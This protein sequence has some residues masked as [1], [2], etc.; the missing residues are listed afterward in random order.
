M[1]EIN[2]I[3]MLGV[4]GTGM[5]SLA[6]LLKQAG[7]KVS[8]SDKKLYPPMS[9][10]LAELNIKIYE[11]FSEKNLEDKP[12]LVVIGNVITKDNIEAQQVL[13]RE[14]PYISMPQALSKFFLNSRTPIVVAGTHGKTTTSMLLAWCFFSAGKEPGF[15]IGGVGNNFK[16]TA[17]IGKGSPFII[18]GDEYDTAFFDKGPKFL[19]YSP[20]IVLLTSVEFDHGD[21]YKDLEQIKK[22]FA[23][24]ISIIPS[25]GLLVYNGDDEN[26]REL[27]KASKIRSLSYGMSPVLDYFPSSFSFSGNGTSFHLKGPNLST[28]FNFA[29]F[30]EHNLQNAMGVIAVLKELGMSDEDIEKGLTTFLGVRRRQEIA[31]EIKSITIVDDFAHHPTAVA[32]TIQAIKVKFPERRLWAIFEPRSN[33]SRRN[34]F[35]EEYVAALSKADRVVIG[36]VYCSEKIPSDERLDVRGVAAKIMRKGIDAHYI[37]NTEFIIEFLMRNINKNDVILVMSNGDFNNLIS[38]IKEGLNK[39][40]IV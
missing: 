20:K 36:D 30:G 13:K 28:N 23:K 16:K 10:Q 25:D 19:H 3:H 31:A 11:G 24:L 35:K 7:Y 12:D 15:F 8:G 38:K 18:E 5:G 32:K 26:I 37:P 4:G 39:R 6:R 2:H 21:I 1:K 22:A 40:K 29:M 14:I 17:D 33:T 9:D 27:V 34:I